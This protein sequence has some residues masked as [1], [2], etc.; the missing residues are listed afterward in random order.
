[1]SFILDA[2]KKSESDRQLRNRP[3]GAYVPTGSGDSPTSKWLWI[4][5]ALVTINVA[6]VLFVV[7][8]PEIPRDLPT[9]ADDLVDAGEFPGS[10]DKTDEPAATFKE[11]VDEAKG[12]QPAPTTQE[13]GSATS[14]ST[15]PPAGETVPSATSKAFVARS[16]QPSTVT[17]SYQTF[18]EVRA[19]GLVSLPELH[20][21]IHVYSAAAGE[22][23]VF[24]N[25]SKYKE[26]AILDEGPSVAEIVPEGVILDYLGTQFLLPRE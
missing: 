12:S 22:R 25:M 26:N 14:A 15:S 23:F 9:P 13:N 20:L 18:N 2:L 17:T 10:S 19:K 21:D 16:S 3:E 24:I 4:V 8:R 11:L 7:L 1:M 5:G 6:V